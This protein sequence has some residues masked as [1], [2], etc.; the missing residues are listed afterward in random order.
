MSPNE[1]AL[2]KTSLQLER[3]LHVINLMVVTTRIEVELF[4]GVYTIIHS[5]MLDISHLD[6]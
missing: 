2:I 6:S 5:L 1:L 3:A 4:C